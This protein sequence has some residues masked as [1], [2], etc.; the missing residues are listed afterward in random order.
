MR[1]CPLIHQHLDK[2]SWYARREIEEEEFEILVLMSPPCM[3]MY[4]GIRSPVY[5]GRL[6]GP[7]AKPTVKHETTRVT[8]PQSTLLAALCTRVNPLTNSAKY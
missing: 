3:Y 1:P 5:P 2:I 8:H 6:F 7:Q 4:V